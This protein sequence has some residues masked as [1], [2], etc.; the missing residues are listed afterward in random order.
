MND[1][2]KSKLIAQL[3]VHGLSGGGLN[4]EQASLL[5]NYAKE[6][7]EALLAKENTL[8]KCE[9]LCYD[10]VKCNPSTVK[11]FDLIYRTEGARWDYTDGFLEVTIHGKRFEVRAPTLLACVEEFLKVESRFNVS[12]PVTTKTVFQA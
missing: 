3:M 12:V 4:G 9:L 1:D 7:A 5:A 11:F 6:V 2:Q 10:L 8:T